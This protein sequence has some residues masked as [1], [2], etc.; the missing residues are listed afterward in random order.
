VDNDSAA[1]CNAVF[2]PPIALASGY[3]GYVVTTSFIWVS[4]GCT[5]V[6]LVLFGLVVVA[7]L[8]VLVGV[9]VLLCV[10]RNQQTKRNQK[11]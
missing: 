7:A 1:H 4:L 10:S 2:F 3:S 5:W 11:Q 6:L 8:S 9:G